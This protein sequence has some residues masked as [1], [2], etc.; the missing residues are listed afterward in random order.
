MGRIEAGPKDY[1][2]ALVVNEGYQRNPTRP[3]FGV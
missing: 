1:K 3:L 2:R